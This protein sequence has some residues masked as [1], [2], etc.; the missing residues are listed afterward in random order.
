MEYNGPVDGIR[1]PSFQFEDL[2]LDDMLTLLDDFMLPDEPPAWHNVPIPPVVVT[3]PPPPQ[4]KAT[5]GRRPIGLKPKRIRRERRE[6]L[7]LRQQVED[8]G[9]T[10]TRLTMKSQK[11]ARDHSERGAADALTL[12]TEAAVWKQVA[13][14]HLRRR[15]TSETENKR[16]KAEVQ[17]L[18]QVTSKLEQILTAGAI[19]QIMSSINCTAPQTARAFDCPSI[20]PIVEDQVLA[21]EQAYLQLDAVLLA[22]GFSRMPT[23]FFDVEVVQDA[24][25]S[26]AI[27]MKSQREL[28]YD[29]ATTKKVMWKFF[30]GDCVS[31]QISANKAAIVSDYIVTR[32]VD[33]KEHQ[34][35]HTI[36]MYDNED[37]TAFV[38]KT[39]VSQATTFG[40][41]LSS[42][43]ETQGQQVLRSKTV[44]SNGRFTPSTVVQMF[45]K[46]TLDVS[47]ACPE[48]SMPDKHSQAMSDMVLSIKKAY[49]DM[50]AHMVDQLATE[51]RWQQQQSKLNTGRSV[52]TS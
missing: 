52:R 42:L 8:L 47:G 4:T 7:Y 24:D 10:L 17:E 2:P 23:M 16:L 32:T 31:D 38:W 40:H 15:T 37:R 6:M 13:K 20:F 21:L 35:Q 39:R 22:S 5:K 26:V 19:N 44:E 46:I 18:V 49:A 28:A 34:G 48:G 50:T 11:R 25:H 12:A 43:I 29:L 30:S 41:A 45:C 36:R 51:E 14:Q 9:Q 3:P 1:F 27:E 33:D